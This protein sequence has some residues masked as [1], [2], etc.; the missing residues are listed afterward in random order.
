VL[1]FFVLVFLLAPKANAQSSYWKNYFSTE[2]R[3][4]VQKNAEKYTRKQIESKSSS[5]KELIRGY[6]IK[7][8]SITDE[9]IKENG[10][11]TDKISGLGDYIDEKIL[12]SS[13]TQDFSADKLTGSYAALDGSQ[14][15]GIT[16]GQ[17]GA[18]SYSGA[19]GVVDLNGKNLVN[20]G[21][22]G[23][24]TTEPIAPL[25]V[26]NSPI[27]NSSDAV[28]L[29][30]RL[31]ND[32][33]AGSGINGHAF[34]DSSTI[35]RGGAIGYNSFDGRAIISGSNDFNH[36]A[37]FQNGATYGSSGTMGIM[38]GFINAPTIT[39]GT[40]TSM[41]GAYTADPIGGGTVINNYGVFV[42][43]LSK[44][45]TKN[46]AIYTAGTTQSWF[47]GAVGIGG[48]TTIGSVS[49]LGTPL[50]VAGSGG[51]IATLNSASSGGPYLTLQSS[52]AT[53]GYVGGA[54]GIFSS[55]YN[56]AIGIRSQDALYFGTN[57]ANIRMTIDKNVG[58][59]G[60]GTTTPVATLDINGTAKLKKY[61]S[62]PFA[63][64]A[65]HDGTTALTSGYRTCVCKGG[66]TIWVFTT[67]GTTTCTW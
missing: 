57:G 41:Y 10:I 67:D 31:V 3:K 34:S 45:V 42:P 40:I 50:S 53:I 17:I 33:G 20:V 59:V 18:I 27:S 43:Q 6:N 47:G 63:C 61:S 66:T 37:V 36:Y 38:Y 25:H 2:E 65:T 11:S 64:D 48:T 51:G 62:Q 58:N 35:T 16:A 13:T 23:I 1:G 32:T 21:N 8:G 60:I 4:A 54:G 49:T 12:N 52:G 39:A 22:V 46:Y 7:N 9:D 28:I 15:T 44:G 56:G 14:I 55:T 19:T 24:G 30:S 29:I 26:G 5:W